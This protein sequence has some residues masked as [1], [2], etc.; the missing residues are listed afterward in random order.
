MRRQAY[1]EQELAIL[2]DFVS[3][4]TIGLHAVF[5]SDGGAVC[6]GDGGAGQ[7]AGTARFR[8]RVPIRAGQ[9][10][11]GEQARHGVGGAMADALQRRGARGAGH[12]AGR[13]DGGAGGASAVCAEVL[14]LH[15]VGI[16]DSGRN[17]AHP[18]CVVDC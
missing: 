18:P 4:Y 7:R 15:L 14:P 1:D 6:A 17:P 13:A 8:Q 3:R 9:H 2:Y 10:L 5:L 11:R 16:L 12:G